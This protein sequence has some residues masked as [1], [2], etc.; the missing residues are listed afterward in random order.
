MPKIPASL[1]RLASRRNK[2]SE[3]SPRGQGAYRLVSGALG[4]WGLADGH[5]RIWRFRWLA[6]PHGLVLAVPEGWFGS[7]G[8]GEKFE[9]NR[10]QRSTPKP[11]TTL[12][13]RSGHHPKLSRRLFDPRSTD[14]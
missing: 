4:L 8:T 7:T 11:I 9:D 3:A 14:N 13:K 2:L 1:F 6:R 12:Q 10:A 5:I